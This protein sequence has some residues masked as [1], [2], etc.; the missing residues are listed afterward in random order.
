MERRLKDKL[1]GGTFGDVSAGHAKR[2]KAIRSTGNQSTEKRFRGLL[3]QARVRGWVLNPPG[4]PGKP[5]FLF[6]GP[7]IVVFLDGCYWHGCPR[8]GHVGTVNRAY[9]SAKIQGNR[10]RDRRRTEA[11]EA[12]GYTVLR[13]WE[14]ELAET[15]AD[16]I[17]RIKDALRAAAGSED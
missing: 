9:W 16:C 5:D 11:L 2:M 4:L 10:D 7:R 15:P 3:V 6:P 1:E 8:C 13:F 14:H 12:A 17:V